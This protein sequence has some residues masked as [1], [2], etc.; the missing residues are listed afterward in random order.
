[1]PKIGFDTISLTDA[2][3]KIIGETDNEI[4]MQ[5]VI[6]REIVQPYEEG[7]AYKPGDELEKAAWTAEN[8]WVIALE[9]PATGLLTR[10]EDINGKMSNVKFV[11][12]L[13]DPK[14]KRP[15]VRGIKAD[16]TWFK[17]KTPKAVLDALHARTMSDVSIG[18][19]YEEDMTPGEFNGEH[20]DFVQRNIFIDHLCAPTEIGRCPSPLCGIG[21][22]AVVKQKANA[23]SDSEKPCPIKA[24]LNELNAEGFVKLLKERFSAEELSRL[25]A[26]A[27]PLIAATPNAAT[28]PTG[29]AAAN[30]PSAGQA[31]KAAASPAGNAA[32]A[33]PGSPT[34]A[35]ITPPPDVGAV[36]AMSGQVMERAKRL[37]L[38]P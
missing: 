24:K 25:L 8:R 27:T 7:K 2:Q 4:T 36:I 5:A 6:A 11:K 34:G 20:Y 13:M 15:M 9:H 12:D 33:A 28:S 30:D 10:R 35:A 3:A 23:Q 19:T 32:A 22:D 38:N 17:D 26:P 14:T 21:V 18:F 16:I 1:M 29:Q 37:N 31:G